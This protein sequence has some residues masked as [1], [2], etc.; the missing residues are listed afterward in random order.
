MLDINLRAEDLLRKFGARTGLIGTTQ[1]VWAISLMYQKKYKER[2]FPFTMT[3]L[4]EILVADGLAGPGNRI[5][6]AIDRVVTYIL[7]QEDTTLFSQYFREKPT[8]LEFINTMA[9][10]LSQEDKD[11][12]P[13]ESLLPFSDK[14]LKDELNR[15]EK[16]RLEARTR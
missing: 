13:Q 9:F 1:T 5:G 14:Q 7:K 11:L 2:V 10:I 15:R 8:S 6:K 3:M 12:F 4:Q 16:L